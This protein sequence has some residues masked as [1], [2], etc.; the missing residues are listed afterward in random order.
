LQV[1]RAAA[2]VAVV[3]SLVL[4]GGAATASVAAG[5]LPRPSAQTRPTVQIPRYLYLRM[6]PA[7]VVAV[8]KRGLGRDALAAGIEVYRTE[9]ALANAHPDLGHPGRNSGRRGPLWFVFGWGNFIGHGPLGAEARS[10]CGYRIILDA[11]GG[12]LGAGFPWPR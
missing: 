9:D 1:K 6:R 12:I 8:F 10:P 7:Q 2:L 11:A 4:Q 3:A 5:C